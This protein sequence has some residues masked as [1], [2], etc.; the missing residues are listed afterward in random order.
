M[1]YEIAHVI[2]ESGEEFR[3]SS[4]VYCLWSAEDVEKWSLTSEG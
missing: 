4:N 3:K 2:L 1:A